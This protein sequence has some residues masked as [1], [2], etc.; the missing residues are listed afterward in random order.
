MRVHTVGTGVYKP[1][2]TFSPHSLLFLCPY[3]TEGLTR[4]SSW[5]GGQSFSQVNRSTEIQAFDVGNF[6]ESPAS[7][8]VQVPLRPAPALSQ[9]VLHR[10][11]LE[12]RQQ[13]GKWSVLLILTNLFAK[14]DLP[15]RQQCTDLLFKLRVCA[16]H[17]P[18]VALRIK[19][20]FFSRRIGSWLFLEQVN[21]QQVL[22]ARDQLCTNCDPS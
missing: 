4:V 6:S 22:V 2:P 11:V 18:L 17:N 21:G 15:L 8:R 1:R 12:Q 3:Y 10:G 9:D 14:L 7:A 5:T 20:E 13:H 16:S 19:T